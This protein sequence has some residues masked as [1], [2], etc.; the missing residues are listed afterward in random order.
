MTLR[1]DWLSERWLDRSVEWLSQH[2]VHPYFLLDQTE[3]P[4]F[5]RRFD[6]SLN[7]L[8]GLNVAH[9]WEYAGAP[10]VV[11]YDPLQPE[12]P[13]EKP[14]IFMPEDV[15]TAA[16]PAPADPPVFVLSE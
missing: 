5:R 14:T 2:G 9:V 10:R 6:N 3:L 1:F 12:R 8:G 16:Y 4:D 7:V 11:L 15:K 13:G